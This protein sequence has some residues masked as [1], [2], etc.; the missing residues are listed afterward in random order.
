MTRLSLHT[1]TVMHSRTLED[2]RAHA[3]SL[4]ICYL[5]THLSS[6][7]A[8]KRTEAILQLFPYNAMYDNFRVTIDLSLR[9]P[10]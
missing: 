8:R 10:T 9:Y 1:H 5:L 4:T 2:D 7:V 3:H 6:G